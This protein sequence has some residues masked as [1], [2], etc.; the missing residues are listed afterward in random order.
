MIFDRMLK[1]IRKKAQQSISTSNFQSK[2]M[3]VVAWLRATK[4]SYKLISTTIYF[5]L[6][7]I[8]HCTASSTLK[9][10]THKQ[11]KMFQIN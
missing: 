7:E 3:F 8:P 11:V 5:T 1:L 6:E 2:E 9:T 10:V 4:M